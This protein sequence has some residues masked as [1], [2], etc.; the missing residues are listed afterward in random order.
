MWI[1]NGKQM[2]AVDSEMIDNFKYPSL[3]LME[4]AGQ[5]SAQIIIE[6]YPHIRSFLVVCGAGNNG[7]DGF[8]TARYLAK[9]GKEPLI[10]LSHPVEKLTSDA[11]INFEIVKHN[12]IPF[13]VFSPELQPKI[14]QFLSEGAVIIDAILGVGMVGTLKEPVV[15]LLNFLRTFRQSVVALD[16]PTG[17]SADTGAVNTPPLKCECTITYQLPKICNYITPAANFCGQT[18]IVD[19]GIYPKVISKFD[20]KISLIT[21]KIVNSW[22]RPRIVDSHK[23]SYGHALFAGGS[24]GKGGAIALSANAATEIGAGLCTAFI[25][26]SVACSFHRTTLENMSIPYGTGAIPYLNETAADVFTSYL[27]DKAVVAI[28]PGL[29]NNPD[30]MKF[31]QNALPEIKIPLILDADALNVIAENPHFWELLPK[32][33]PVI[34]T[35]HPGEMS[36]L[37]GLTVEEIQQNRLEKALEFAEKRNI[38]VVLKGAGTIVCHPDGR[39]YVSSIGNP[40]MATGGSGDVLTGVIAGFIAQGYEPF[41]ATALGVYIHAASGDFVMKQFGHEGVTATKIIRHLGQAF[42]EIREI[43][44]VD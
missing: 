30:T 34:F 37:M 12:G 43:A 19:I 14:K 23:G 21:P 5:K 31:M 10:I 2:R 32:E 3:L 6:R 1:V 40:G 22:Y 36:R 9:A 28:G 44:E 25:P 7:G 38:I 41:A 20:F 4:I 33:S 27:G 42:K 13:F 11:L 39:V 29:G 17:L 8:V 15:S 24:K 16:I 35:P 18:V 26:G